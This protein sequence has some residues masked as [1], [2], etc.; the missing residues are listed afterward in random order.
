MPTTPDLTKRARVAQNK[1]VLMEYIHKR[2]ATDA[3]QRALAEQAQARRDRVKAARERREDRQAKAKAD[4]LASYDE[5]DKKG[6]K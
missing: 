4:L 1:R 2:K 5:Q 6:K 3:R